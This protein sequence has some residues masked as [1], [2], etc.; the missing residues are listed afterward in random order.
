MWV[1]EPG[2]KKSKIGWSLLVGRIKDK[3]DG[4]QGDAVAS[5]DVIEDH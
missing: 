5:M 2:K 4:E 3:K 1:L